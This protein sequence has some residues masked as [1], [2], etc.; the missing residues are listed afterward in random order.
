M[1][2]IYIARNHQSLGSFFQEDVR[3]GILSGRFM[4]GDLA[5]REGMSEWRPLGE[6][7]PQWEIEI[8]PP[9][10]LPVDGEG[11]SSLGNFP[12]I[13]AEGS[14]PAWEERGS[15]GSVPAIFRTLKAVLFRPTATFSSLKHTGG[16]MSP[17]LYTILLNTTLHTLFGLLSLAG[18][19]LMSGQEFES[20]IQ[21]L[22]VQLHAFQELSPNFIFSMPL[23]SKK[24]IEYMLLGNIFL[25]PVIAVAANFLGAGILHLSLRMVGGANRPFETTFRFTCYLCGSFN[26]VAIVLDLI[27]GIGAAGILLLLMATLVYLGWYSY[28]SVVAIQQ[29]QSIGVWKVLLASLV[30]SFLGLFMLV[31][32]SIMLSP[33]IVGLMKMA[34]FSLGA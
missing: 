22:Q 13:Q 25:W 23:I 31:A 6:M 33:L 12:R 28:A 15:I 10:L 32:L 8:P 20:K 5:W 21:L 29:A 27:P 11:D 18:L 7:A 17:L 14:E 1:P 3:Q 9:S 24:F 16:L 2:K 34:G 4:A 26:A 30:F 19:L